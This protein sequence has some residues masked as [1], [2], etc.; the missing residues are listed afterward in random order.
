VKALAAFES[1]LKL[2]PDSKEMA[3]R[4]EQLKERIAAAQ[5]RCQHTT[6]AQTACSTR[7]C[8]LARHQQTCS[9]ATMPCVHLAVLIAPHV[10]ELA[11]EGSQES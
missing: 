5:V 8:C 1:G 3:D 2:D 9:K 6:H 4:V 11:G 7:L 10:F